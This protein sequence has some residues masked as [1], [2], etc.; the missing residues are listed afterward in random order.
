MGDSPGLPPSP[1]DLFCIVV[2]PATEGW[3]PPYSRTLTLK[4]LQVLPAPPVRIA[5]DPMQRTVVAGPCLAPG[6]SRPSWDYGPIVRSLQAAS[7]VS[8]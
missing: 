1:G 4:Q 8:G 7:P 5:P 2:L 6:S 3:R